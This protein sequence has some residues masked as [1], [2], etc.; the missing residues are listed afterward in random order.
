MRPIYF[1]NWR[2]RLVG[3]ESFK[4]FRPEN[5]T[6]SCPPGILNAAPRG[7]EATERERTPTTDVVPLNFFANRKKKWKLIVTKPTNMSCTIEQSENMKSPFTFIRRYYIFMTAATWQHD[8]R[9]FWVRNLDGSLICCTLRP[10]HSLSGINGCCMPIHNARKLRCF[11]LLAS[12]I[13]IMFFLI[14]SPVAWSLSSFL[15]IHRIHIKCEF[16]CRCCS[17][18]KR[19][20]SI[21]YFN[22][23]DKIYGF[24][25]V[26]FNTS[27]AQIAES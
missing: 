22:N 21:W 13:D 2:L 9:F 16:T 8:L 4:C 19:L 11:H 3:D 12:R 5:R 18:L 1:F 23:I 17:M 7:W 15:L 24:I 25:H 10:L 26:S 27:N 6:R 20:H 14:L